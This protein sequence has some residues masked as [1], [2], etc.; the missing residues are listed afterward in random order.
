MNKLL[1]INDDILYLNRRCCLMTFLR[2]AILT[3][4]WRSTC[5]MC[6]NAFLGRFQI[7]AIRSS[8][9][10][11]QLLRQLFVR[12]VAPVYC[13][14]IKLLIWPTEKQPA[15]SHFYCLRLLA[16]SE[17]RHIH[18]R[19]SHLFERLFLISWENN[20]DCYITMPLSLK[21]MEVQIKGDQWN[22]RFRTVQVYCR[23]YPNH[24]GIAPVETRR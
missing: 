16:I 9:V 2:T 21:T 15:C 13:I 7:R 17:R 10:K 24:Y 8:G 19:S 4:R 12:T 3:Q 5:R 1:K 20:R 14:L 18:F 6:L 11:R 23:A 22:K